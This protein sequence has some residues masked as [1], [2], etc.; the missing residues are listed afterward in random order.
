MCSVTVT[1]SANTRPTKRADAPPL[2]AVRDLSVSYGPLQALSLVNLSVGAGEVVA[3]AGENGAGK[4]T[5][6]RCIGGDITPSA[7]EIL[8]DGSQLPAGHAAIGRQGI[9]VL[10]QD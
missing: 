1:T 6:V 4:S 9:S 10:W 8:I 7:G 5:L 2:L 3:L